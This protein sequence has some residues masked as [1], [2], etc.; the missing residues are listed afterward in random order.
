MREQRLGF[1]TKLACVGIGV[2]DGVGVGW[3]YIQL[4]SGLL[5]VDIAVALNW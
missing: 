3:R 2:G 5:Y 4:V 1:L